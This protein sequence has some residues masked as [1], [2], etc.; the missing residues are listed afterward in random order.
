MAV[1]TLN[2]LAFFA[3]AGGLELGLHIAEPNY[4]TICYCEREAS[5]AAS[6][7][8]RM[9]DEALDKAIKWSLDR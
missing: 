8:A 7:V 4:R 3:G 6:L 9:E 5:A 1:R 2:G